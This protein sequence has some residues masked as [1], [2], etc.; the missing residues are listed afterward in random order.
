MDGMR[1]RQVVEVF[2]SGAE[3]LF[4][5]GGVALGELPARVQADGLADRSEGGQGQD[6]KGEQG[7][8]VFVG[9]F[10]TNIR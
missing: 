9:W 8:H 10:I 2:G 7:M 3:I 5:G 6:A 4:R 1:L